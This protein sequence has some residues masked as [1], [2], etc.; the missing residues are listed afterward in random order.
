MTKVAKLKTNHRFEDDEEFGD[1]LDRYRSDNWTEGDINTINSRIIDARTGMMS[2]NND[3]VDV[4]YA[5]AYN[6]ERNAVTKTIFSRH[7]DKSYPIVK[8]GDDDQSACD[9]IPRHTIII[10]SLIETKVGV[11]S[12]VFHD[13]AIDNHGDADVK[14]GTSKHIDP[15]LILY[16]GIPLM[17]T[18]NKDIEKGRGN[19]TLCRGFSVKL[20]THI[21]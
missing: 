10:E 14:V 21:D 6:K 15:A 4:T 3:N 17:K 9:G 5:C 8:P 12:E 16:S 13:Y 2:P 19:G 1:L 7:V 20:K 11:R 18:T